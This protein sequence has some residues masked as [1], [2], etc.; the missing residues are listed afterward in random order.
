MIGR[1]VKGFGQAFDVSGEDML[2]VIHLDEGHVK[3]MKDNA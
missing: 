1:Y 2:S 3:Q